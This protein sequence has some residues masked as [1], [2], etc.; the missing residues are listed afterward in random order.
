MIDVFHVAALFVEHVRKAYA[1]EVGIIAYY[2]SYARGTASPTSDLDLYYILDEGK[3]QDL[4]RS[5]VMEHLPFEFWPI[6][7]EFAEKIA[8]GRHAWSVAP[9]LLT[10]AEVLYVRSEDDLQRF[11]ALKAKIHELQQPD[12][13]NDMVRLAVEMFQPAASHLENLRLACNRQDMQG[14]R[15]AGFSLMTTI[16]DCL[17]LLNQASFPKFWTACA[18]QIFALPIKP[19]QFDA[20]VKTISTSPEFSA[21]QQA[22]ETLLHRTQ[23]V[24]SQEHQAICTLKPANEELNGYYPA[25]KEYVYKILA[26]CDK[27]NLINAAYW[28]SK[29]QQE[30]TE[31]LARIHTGIESSSLYSYGDYRRDFDQQQF[32]DLSQ[33]ISAGD[34]DRL[35]TLVKRFDER[36]QEYFTQN[37]IPLHCMTS[38]KELR[39]FMQTAW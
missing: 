19:E 22:A 16:V 18:E 30:L 34:F 3:A 4:Y 27:R 10:Q 32:P 6:S 28:A 39:T 11:N 35:A 21:I 17:A 29:M 12:R 36:A 31:M 33:A 14:A 2:G 15:W 9:A 1:D 24:L 20:L 25:I 23:N 5:F 8:S 26:A 13:K 38:F 7:W 37:S